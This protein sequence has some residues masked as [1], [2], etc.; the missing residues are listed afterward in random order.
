MKALKQAEVS[1]AATGLKGIDAEDG[2]PQTRIRILTIS[3]E[4]IDP[5]DSPEADGQ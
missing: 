4:T 3:R 5:V 2:R 1:D